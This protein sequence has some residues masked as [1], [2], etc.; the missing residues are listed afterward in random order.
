MLDGCARSVLGDVLVVVSSS[1]SV[2]DVVAAALGWLTCT[3]HC[4]AF[5]TYIQRGPLKPRCVDDDA[6]DMH[7][8]CAQCVD[9]FA[10]INMYALIKTNM[11]RAVAG[12][13]AR[14][15]ILRHFA[16]KRVMQFAMEPIARVHCRP[17]RFSLLAS[18][19]VHVVKTS[20]EPKGTLFCVTHNFRTIRYIQN[21]HALN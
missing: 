14:V 5:V 11:A 12:K 9:G 8:P 18:K 17:D 4:T 3:R 20:H 15:A 16:F 13:G 19:V 6:D 21:A 7:G 2:F 1:V 10:S